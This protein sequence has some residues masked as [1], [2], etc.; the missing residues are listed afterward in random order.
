MRYF[1]PFLCLLAACGPQEQHDCEKFRTGEFAFETSNHRY[2]FIRNDSIQKE[3]NHNT[4]KIT[5]LSVKWISPCEYELAYISADPADPA[6][7]IAEKKKWVL[8]TKITSTGPD[9]YEF[10]SWEEG[11]EFQLT[12]RIR[13]LKQ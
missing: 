12:G 3:I 13:L 1:I 10:T 4:G 2:T 8:K 6:P 5:T 9:F 11:D 7:E